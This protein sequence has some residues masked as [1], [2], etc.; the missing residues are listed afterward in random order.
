MH[1]LEAVSMLF[2]VIWVSVHQEIDANFMYFILG[3]FNDAY[4]ASDEVW[5]WLPI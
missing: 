4:I 3:L 2:Y 1:I 5:K